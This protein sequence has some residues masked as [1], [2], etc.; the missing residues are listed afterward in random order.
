MRHCRSLILGWVSLVSFL[1]VYLSQLQAGSKVLIQASSTASFTTLHLLVSMCESNQSPAWIW[2]QCS[3]CMHSGKSLIQTQWDWR[4]VR[5]LKLHDRG[6]SCDVILHPL[7]MSSQLYNN[8]EVH[9]PEWTFL[10][11]TIHDLHKLS[12]AAHKMLPSL[13]VEHWT[14]TRMCTTI[15]NQSIFY[16]YSQ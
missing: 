3:T 4:G 12:S 11:L 9:L 5:Q 2:A 13:K 16:A 8:E 1:H 15:S 14:T 6:R 10:V 7:C